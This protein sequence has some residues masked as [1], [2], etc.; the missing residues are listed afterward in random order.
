MRRSSTSRGLVRQSALCGVLAIMLAACGA[1]A[2]TNSDASGNG[3][4][5]DHM[6][7]LLGS[8]FPEAAYIAQ[9]QGFFEEQNLD[10]N[11]IEGGNAAEQLPQLLSGQ[12]DVAITGGV[13]L[14][15]AVDQ[16]LDVKMFL[17]QQRATSDDSTSGMLVKADSPIK[18]YEDL[19]GKTI[20]LQGLKETTHL[21]T[22]MAAQ[23]AGV[24]TNSMRFVQLPLPNIAEATANGTV[25]AGYP[26]SVFYSRGVESGLRTIGSPTADALVD[27]PNVVWAATSSYIEQNK[28]VLERFNSAITKATM[29]AMSDSELFRTVQQQK[30]QLPV[31]YIKSAP[32][33]ELNTSI[34]RSG[35]ERSLD[36]LQQFKFIN[37]SMTF[38]DVVAD[39]APVSN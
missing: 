36:G 27:G 38:D 22:L 31:E 32:I 25:D 8:V 1:N 12:V 19:G 24:D 34:S 26:L 3:S 2:N 11:L 28:S 33:A 37:S 39:I 23:A 15:E 14:I 13:P 35:V 16:G 30:T 20:A 21:G 18:G 7:V 6:D 17:G 4:G 29:L 9:E 5:R 10:V